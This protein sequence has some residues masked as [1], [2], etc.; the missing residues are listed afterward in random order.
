MIVRLQPW[1]GSCRSSL[2]YSSSVSARGSA[3]SWSNA[4]SRWRNAPGRSNPGRLRRGV[5]VPS[6]ERQ[7]YVAFRANGG[8]QYRQ[9]LLVSISGMIDEGF[10]RWIREPPD[11][12]LGKA[13]KS[14][15]R[16]RRLTSQGSLSF[17]PNLGRSDD[18]P[19]AELTELKHQVTGSG[20]GSRASDHHVGIHEHTGQPNRLRIRLVQSDRCARRGSEPAPHVRW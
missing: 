4:R 15:Q 8:H 19:Q 14:R 20:G 5:V 16:R 9:V 2:P 11:R 3:R 13:A 17:F 18:L 7:E 1:R 6:V 12:S 10:G